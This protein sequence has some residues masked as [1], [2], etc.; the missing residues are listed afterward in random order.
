MFY[1]D[2]AAPDAAIPV[3]AR[4]AARSRR[5]YAER[6][7]TSVRA[8]LEQVL[9]QASGR[10]RTND[11]AH[12]PGAPLAPGGFDVCRDNTLPRRDEAMRVARE[13][14]ELVREAPHGAG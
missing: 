1:V 9:D 8:S 14:Y 11:L 2:S 12:A 5:E 7:A 4:R 13:A 6:A 3:P 10:K